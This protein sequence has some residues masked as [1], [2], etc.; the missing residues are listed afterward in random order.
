MRIRKGRIGLSVLVVFVLLLLVIVRARRAEPELEPEPE[1]IPIIPLAI[2]ALDRIGTDGNV[3]LDSSGRTVLLRGFVTITHNTGG[4]AVNYTPED[5]QTMKSLGANYQSIRIFGGNIG[6]WPGSRVSRR[7]LRRLDGM[8]EMAKQAGMYSEIKLTM[9]GIRGFDWTDLWLNENGEQDAVIEGWRGVWERYK[10][11]PAIFG[12]DLLNEPRKGDLNVS[13]EQ[14]VNEFLIPFYQRII[15]EFRKVD[16][17]SLA[18]FQPALGEFDF[19]TG[20]VNYLSYDAPINRGNVVYAPHL[21][22]DIVS[23]STDTYGEL[24]EKYTNEALMHKAPL[25]IGEF[26]VPWRPSEDGNSRAEASHQITE[27]TALDL[28]DQ[29]SIGFSRPWFADD[30]AGITIG[31]QVWSWSL[32]SGSS[33]LKGKQ[34]DFIFDVLVRPYPRRTA[35]TLGPLSYDIDTKK[36]A[37]SYTPS[38]DSGDT[39]IFIP[40]ERQYNNGFTVSH[41]SGVTLRLSSSSSFLEVTSNPGGVD[42]GRFSWDQANQLLSISGSE[43]GGIVTIEVGP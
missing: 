10:D 31:R 29:A 6:G 41:S 3:L 14:F 17:R 11:E 13:D 2:A 39:L 23:F 24:F 19:S 36:F 35:G 1:Q 32:I 27:A 16:Q 26:G 40:Q 21:Y 30:R 42:E 9:F 5:Y 34:R 7:Y 15:D 38:L 18:L 8:V 33:G 43:V 28:F 37:M 22:S 4:S 25:F 12:Y 20:R